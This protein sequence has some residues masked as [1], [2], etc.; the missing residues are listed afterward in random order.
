[1]S[2]GVA[3]LLLFASALVGQQAVSNP[4]QLFQDAV[5]AQQ[6]GDGAEALRM[7]RE[8]IRIDP[9]AT[10]V[11]VNLDAT[12]AHM[13]RFDEAIAQYRTVLAA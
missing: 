9:G 6:R 13:G 8:L 2:R 1:M 12:L 4:E 7:Y 5:R 3:A 10:G 11:R